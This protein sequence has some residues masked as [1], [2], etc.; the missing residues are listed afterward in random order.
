MPLDSE[1]PFAK[2]CAFARSFFIA[3]FDVRKKNGERPRF[4]AGE[5]YSRQR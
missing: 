3:F 5:N 2:H 4:C 1:A